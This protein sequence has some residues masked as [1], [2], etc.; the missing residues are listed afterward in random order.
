[1]QKVIFKPRFSQYKDFTGGQAVDE[2]AP[3]KPAHRKGAQLTQFFQRS[4]A[5]LF[6]G[7]IAMCRKVLD[8]VI[9]RGCNHADTYRMPKWTST[10]RTTNTMPAKIRSETMP[11]TIHETKIIC[12]VRL[13]CWSK[14]SIFCRSG[15]LFM[16]C[17]P[18]QLEK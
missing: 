5:Q 4:Q 8:N 15:F 16:P 6:K 3:V 17:H 2:R 9:K 14:S 18:F 11:P 10:L 7:W 12:C 13:N 1:R